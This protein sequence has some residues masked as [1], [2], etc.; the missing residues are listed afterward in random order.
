MQK[1]L[2]IFFWPLLEALAGGRDGQGGAALT[3]TEATA[4]HILETLL[5][6][7]REQVGA[8][9]SDVASWILLDPLGS[10]WILL[11]PLGSS[12]ILLDPL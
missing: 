3:A 4:A 5:Q 10:S 9:T 8:R 11:D 2:R 6:A 7:L 1:I 12:W